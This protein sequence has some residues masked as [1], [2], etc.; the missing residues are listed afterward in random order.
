MEIVVL[1]IVIEFVFLGININV[2]CPS[3]SHLAVRVKLTL[4]QAQKRLYCFII[5][6]RLVGL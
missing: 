5:T 4:S 6:N 1:Q 2:L 3:Q